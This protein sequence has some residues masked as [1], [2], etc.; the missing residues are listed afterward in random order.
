[1][2]WHTKFQV[3]SIILT[4]F[5]QGVILLPPT[6]PQNE[7]LKGPPRLGWREVNLSFASHSIKQLETV[8]YHDCQ[9]DSNLSGETM[10]SIVLKKINTKLK[11]MYQ[12]SRYL[13]PAYKRLFCNALI[14]QDFDYG[15]SSWFPLLKKKIKL[16]LQ[17]APNK[18][19]FA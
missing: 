18:C 14:Q 5:R 19:T 17:K 1:M 8:E 11:F 12:Q 2:H 9:L 10:A 13:T 3:S 4:S 16:K 7:L 6:P 15:C